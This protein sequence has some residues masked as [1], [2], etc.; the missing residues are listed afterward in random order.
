VRHGLNLVETI[1][2]LIDKLKKFLEFFKDPLGQ[3]RDRAQ[4]KLDE[5][6]APFNE[7]LEKASKKVAVTAD[8][9]QIAQVNQTLNAPGTGYDVGTGSQPWENA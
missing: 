6:I 3:L 4:Q 2:K 8:L 1:Q 7:K 9:A 5:T